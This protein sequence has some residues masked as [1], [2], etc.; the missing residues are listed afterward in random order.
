M[1]NTNKL[2]AGSVFSLAAVLVAI[3]HTRHHVPEPI[4]AAQEQQPYTDDE[5]PC[6]MGSEDESPCGLGD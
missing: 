1:K 2:I 3:D 4:P 6:G 5:S